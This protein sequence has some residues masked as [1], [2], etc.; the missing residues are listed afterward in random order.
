MLLEPASRV[1]SG[2]MDS[3]LDSLSKSIRETDLI[4]WYDRAEVLGVIF[5]EVGDREV[6]EI[7]D[8]LRSKV[9]GILRT[10]VSPQDISEFRL[11]FHVF[12]DAC[13]N[14]NGGYEFDLKLYPGEV[15]QS[16]PGRTLKRAIDISGSALGLIL[17]SPLFVAI[18]TAIKLTSNG[19]VFFRQKRVGLDGRPFLFLKFRSMYVANDENIHKNYVTAFIAG[20]CTCGRSAEQESVY[21]IQND[22]RVTPVGRLLRR[23]SCD[24]LPQLFN[25][26]AGQMSLVGPRPPV[27]YEVAC[28]EVWHRRRLIGVKPGI[29]G[30]WQVGGRSRVKFNDMVRLDLQYARNWSLGLDF[31]ILLKTPAAVI[32]GDGAY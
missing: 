32:S 5:T 8:V 15:R 10:C 11:S 26:L 14:R 22:P 12:P 4:G 21:K 30:L 2:A 27:P 23:S 20:D 25:V 9:A 24:E 18:A 31:K 28:Y 6:L 1:P 13:S 7:V 3:F 29:T 19:P 16:A 17:L